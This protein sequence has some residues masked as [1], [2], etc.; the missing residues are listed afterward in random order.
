MLLHQLETLKAKSADSRLGLLVPLGATEQHGPHMAFG[1][2]TAIAKRLCC[3]AASQH[4]FSWA[5][6][7][8]V[9]ITASGE[10]Q[11]FPGTL[12]IGTHALKTVLVELVRSADF[13]SPVVLVNAHG[14]NYQA[15]AQ[16][17]EQLKAESRDCWQY[18]VSWAPHSTG[19]AHA[20]HSETSLM[21]AIDTQMV[22][23]GRAEAGRSEPIGQ[24]MPDLKKHGVA[25]VSPNGVLGDPRQANRTAGEAIFNQALSQLLELLARSRQI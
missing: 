5:V 16:A 25:V 19:D 1:V 3:E 22:D 23:M 20:G 7:P 17:V 24:L 13:F 8:A 11:D 12:S 4:D 6:A 15:V 18:H 9:S 21:L 2:D 10:H 14:G